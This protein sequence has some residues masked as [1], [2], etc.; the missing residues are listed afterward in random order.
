[1]QRTAI[2][3]LSIGLVLVICVGVSMVADAKT[4][5]VSPTGDDISGDGTAVNPWRTIQHAVTEAGNGDII[6]L[7]DDD[8]VN[9]T[10]Y[11]ENVLVTKSLTIQRYST[12]SFNPQVKAADGSRH[13]FWVTADNVSIEGLDIYGALGPN[14]GI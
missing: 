7:M 6:K 13:V 4:Y 3:V 10:D 12:I 11:T 8:N 9:T 5:V 1:M 14:A 2:A